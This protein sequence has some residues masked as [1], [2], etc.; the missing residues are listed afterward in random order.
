MSMIRLLC[1]ECMKTFLK[2]RTYL[3]FL[4]ILVVVPLVEIA[5]K[6]EGGRFTE[7]SLRSFHQDFFF[8][9]SLFNGWFVAHQLMNS[10]WV[11]IPLLISFVAGDQLAGEATAGTYRLLLIRPVSRTRIFLAKYLTTLAYAIIFVSF[12]GVFSIGLALLLMGTGDLLVFRGGILVL[13][14]SD[15]AWRFFAAY[16]LA[17]W[18]MATIATIAFFFSSFVENAIGPIVATM[19]VLIVLLIVGV[20]P[21]EYFEAIRPYLFTSHLNVWMGLFAEPVDWSD[22]VRSLAWLGGTSVVFAAAAWAIFVRKDI[23]T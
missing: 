22:I 3:G 18:S 7:A 13:P 4:I 2:K 6:I 20:L 23:L 21:G 14:A 11:H 12:L 9:G 16:I 10:L 15:V 19:G 1:A 17:G 8:I 5:M